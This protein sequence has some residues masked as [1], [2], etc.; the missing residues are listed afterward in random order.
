MTLKEQNIAK[1]DFI[2][3]HKW[4]QTD[5]I[6]HGGSE[7]VSGSSQRGVD[8]KAGDATE[9]LFVSRNSYITLFPPRS[10]PT[11]TTITLAFIS[12]EKLKMCFL[13][14]FYSQERDS[15]VFHQPEILTF[16][17]AVAHN[18]DSVIDQLCVA[19]RNVVQT[20]RRE[21]CPDVLMI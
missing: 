21:N 20:W 3:H 11:G 15:P 2:M 9:V 7:D 18:Q 10:S 8:R 4:K 1:E 19:V 16:G 6:I 17:R 13:W 5:K 12:L 14:T